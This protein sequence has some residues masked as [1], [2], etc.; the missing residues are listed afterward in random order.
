MSSWLLNAYG[1]SG[2]P[3]AVPTA[4]ALSPSSPSIPDNT[5]IGSTVAT[6][7][8]T[9]SDASTFAGTLAFA[10]PNNNDG[11][12]FSIFNSLL[13]TAASLPVGA[14]TQNITLSASQNGTTITRNFAISVYDHTAET[15]LAPLSI[16]NTTASTQTNVP[17]EF[18]LP[19]LGG[20]LPSSGASIKVYDSDGVT[21]LA[22]QE[23]N[24]AS[25]LSGNVRFVKVTGV[26]PTLNAS[27]T[28]TLTVKVNSSTAAATGT[29]ISASDILATAYDC[30]VSAIGGTYTASARTGLAAGAFT[31]KTSAY[32]LGTWRSGGGL[33]TEYVVTVPLTNGGT[34]H[35]QLRAVFHIA[36]YK[37]SRG[38]VG[39]GNPITAIRTD[40]ILETGWVQETSANAIGLWYD[41]TIASGT[42]SVSYANT[43]PAVNLTLSTA[44]AGGFSATCT[45]ASSLFTANDVGRT[46]ADGTG[47]AIIVGYTSGTSVKVNI[48]KAFGST[49]VNS[50]T[51]TIYGLNHPYGARFRKRLWWSGGAQPAYNANLGGAWNGVTALPSLTITN[52]GATGTQTCTAS[53]GTPFSATSVGGVIADSTG[54]AIITGY[55]SSTVVTVKVQ[56]SFA[57][58]TVTSASLTIGP[59]GYLQSTKMIPNYVTAPS[60]ITNDLTNLNACGTNPTAYIST[61]VTNGNAGDIL[62][63]MPQVGGRPDIAPLPG[64]FVGALLRYDANAPSVIYGNADKGNLITWH[65]RDQNTGKVMRPDNGTNY[66]DN[67]GPFAGTRINVSGPAGTSGSIDNW[68]RQVAHHPAVHY[69]PYML[70]GDLWWI[71][72][73]QFQAQWIWCATDPGYAGSQLNKQLWYNEMRGFGW[74]MRTLTEL[75]CVM[76]DTDKTALGWTKAMAKT[77]L[78]NQYTAT[79]SGTADTAPFPGANIQFVNNTG[80]GKKYATNGVRWTACGGNGRVFAQWMLGYNVHALAHANDLG[81]MSTN[82]A[83]FMNWER[84]G[85][86]TAINNNTEVR[87]EY[88]ST[89][90]WCDAQ[91]PTTTMLDTWAKSYQAGATDIPGSVGN[92]GSSATGEGLTTNTRRVNAA[93][94][95][96]AL[97]GTAVTVTLPAGTVS[98]GG[99]TFYA[100][101]GFHDTANFSVVNTPTISNGGSGYAVNDT[102]TLT[103]A[104]TITTN[105]RAVITVTGVTGG[106]ITSISVQ[107]AGWYSWVNTSFA[108]GNYS[109]SQFAT[110]GAGT[111]ATFS[112]VALF[113]GLGIIQSVSGET[114]TISTSA[115]S[116]VHDT[117]GPING[118]PFA[119]LSINALDYCIPWPAPSDN[120]G[121]EM[122]GYI[123]QT[124][125]YHGNG[126]YGNDYDQIAKSCLTI[127]AQD[128]FAGAST[129]LATFNSIFTKTVPQLKWNVAARV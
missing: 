123:N 15:T 127:L 28:R 111:G 99:T 74:A 126:Y 66:F 117:L 59:F 19:L 97:S 4:I 57:S 122:Q 41:L 13:Q 96:S 14:S 12:I 124:G 24:R 56:K 64:W 110:S 91:Y 68:T 93:V 101:G 36:A 46:I 85:I 10:A 81:M 102:I 88:A 58:G 80:T 69:A 112:S 78:E 121:A 106:V 83:A 9:M 120:I 63:Y 33:C 1:S 125:S 7:I 8:V 2:A 31:T 6:I 37:A 86:P 129:A 5:G 65:W 38:A 114:L 43:T 17:F 100:G 116:G 115:S 108:E 95:L 107:D 109:A 39:T 103:V 92:P 3:A 49:A 53:S 51:Y 128:G 50:G 118:R 90:Y 70:S 79:N 44:S 16:V 84:E 32:S 45:A 61:Q 18:G 89:M 55:T 52:A 119:T 25:D 87:P 76:P 40:A 105:R 20:A 21:A 82:G 35:P 104:G 42:N 34:A 73:M 98:G 94:T 62:M 75:T 72:A 11:G 27:E 48:C 113:G 23:D 60:T 77:Y 71:E 54:F 67:T 29:D 47:V 30:T 26:L 22:V